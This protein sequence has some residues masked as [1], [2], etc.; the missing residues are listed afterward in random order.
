MARVVPGAIIAAWTKFTTGS[1]CLEWISR[2]DRQKIVSVW[3]VCMHNK[4]LCPIENS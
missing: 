1:P 4:M 2:F 3:F